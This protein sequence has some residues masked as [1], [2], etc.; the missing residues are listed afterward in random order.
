MATI[1]TRITGATAVNRPLTNT[2]LDNNFINLN[3]AIP[4]NLNQLTNGPGYITGI[5]S[6]NVTTALGFTPYNATN[7]SGYIT[8]ITSANVTTALGFTPYSATNPN[9]YITSY[10]ET[11]T[12]ATVT[13]R[14]AT[15]STAITLSANSNR[16]GNLY[17]GSGT[18]KNNITPV[19]DNNMNLDTPN[20]TVFVTTSIWSPIFYDKDDT[21]YFLDAASNSVLNSASYVGNINFGTSTTQAGPWTISPIASGGATPATKGTGWGRNLVIKAGDSDNN[22]AYG[23]GDLYLRAGS[24]TAPS[25]TYGVVY[26]TDNGG[27]AQ[28]GGSIRAPI[29]YDSNDTNYYC[30]PASTSNFSRTVIN[31]VLTFGPDKHYYLGS[32]SATDTQAVRYE[33]ARLFIDFNDWHAAGTFFVE[34]QS[35]YYA[36]GDW[37]KWAINYD[38]NVGNCYLI[39]GASPSGRLAQVTVGSPVQIS[40]DYYYLPVYVSVR[41]YGRY[42]TY[43]KTSWSLNSSPTN[44]DNGSVWVFTSPSGTNISD[45]TPASAVFTNNILST[46]ADV[47][48]PIFY[49]NNDTNYYLDPASGSNLN[50]TL[51]NN[52]G[53]AMTGGWNRNLMLS[54]T[55]PVLVFNSANAKYSGIGLDYSSPDYAMAF[56]INGTSSDI[57]GTGAYAMRINSSNYVTALGSFRA[58]IFYDSGDTSYYIDANSL[59]SLYGVAIRG[60]SSPQAVDNQLFL[61]GNAG[62]TTSAIGFKQVGGVWAGHGKTSEGYN[63]YFTM[64]SAGRGWV[65]RYAT[66]GGTNFTGTNVFSINNTAGETTIG[67]SWGTSATF[68]QLNVSQGAGSAVTYRDIDLRGSWASGEGHAISATHGSSATNLVGQMVFQHDGTGSRIKWGR[69][70]HSG[71][72]SNYPMELISENSSGQAYLQ[73]NSGSMRA[74]I[75]YD[76]DNTGYY[77]NPNSSSRLG[78]TY[79][80]Q[81]YSYGWF[82]T[83]GIAGLY[84]EDHGNH[85]YATSNTYWNIAGNNNSEVGIIFRTG[86]HQG[87]VRGYLYADSNNNIGFLNTSGS[88]RLRVV[89]GDYSLA[90]GSSMRAPLF[91]DSNDTNYYFDGASTSRWNTSAQN[92]WHTFQDY[93]IG[94]TGTYSSTRLQTVFAMGADYRMAADGNSASNMYGL[95]W[96][97]PN[98]GSLGGANNLNDHGLLIINAGSFRAAISS[99]AVF[100]A[101]VRGTL[102]YDYN[103]TGYY[104]DPTSTTSLRTVG[105]W[106]ADAATWTGEFAGKIQYHSTHWYLQY[107]G[108]T[109]F[110]NS[111]GTDV[112]TIDSSG[113]LVANGNVTA[114]SDRNKKTNIATLTT[115]QQYFDK[116]DAKTFDWKSSGKQD[117]GF[118]AQ[119]VE[120]AGLEMFVQ[121]NEVLDP[122][123][124]E[125]TETVKSL[126][127]GRMVAVLWQTVKELKQELAE[128]K[129]K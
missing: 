38:Y 53:T 35:N 107:S 125:I 26:L 51:V 106:R 32:L 41:Y 92:A 57:S 110:R 27:Y 102:F 10:S 90:D 12:L 31:N 108:T 29:F 18:Y 2:E 95:A 126:D 56:W 52:G 119:D 19:G 127:Y 74:P 33:I 121:N 8:G 128:L 65:F 58:P 45:F 104:L 54:S 116:I 83:F 63:T 75:F 120:A 50:G 59:S 98:A 42:Y 111:S 76:Y 101:D 100:S 5:T 46:S 55:Y 23:G 17:I 68:A 89:G 118:I 64:D 81:S 21:N 96:S 123:T 49:D 39:E 124:G 71:D 113:N 16:I 70:Y 61:W 115:P 9:G 3:S 84:N 69:L 37:Q 30:D 7:P 36:G 93:G 88:W 72:V 62:T 78:T 82:R 91:Y 109:R 97:H 103:D 85:W 6:A 87:T 11:D 15:S 44:A 94:I 4:T 112:L 66:V 105:D 20:G 34:L 80:D 22:A 47:R 40:G 67:S 1:V 129:A 25:T 43:V 117:I 28:A 114:Y 13:G 24:P 73:I 48:A 86:G 99:R 14:G 122:S 79:T 77:L 60:D